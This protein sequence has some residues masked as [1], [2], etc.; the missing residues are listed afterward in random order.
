MKK[1]IVFALPTLQGGGAEKVISII[2]SNLDIR[3]YKIHLVVFDL[4][5]Q[6]YLK[7]EKV[8]IINLNSKKVSLGFLNFISVIKNLNPDILIS[9]VSHL[10][11]FVSVIRKFLPSKLKVITRESNFLSKN[12]KFQSFNYMVKILYKYF[13]NNVDQVIV[14]SK[15]HKLDMIS[16][17]NINSKKIKIIPNPI[18]FENIIKLSKIKIKKKFKK[19]FI[20]HSLKYVFVGSLSFQK[21]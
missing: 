21:G 15:K 17:T 1:K 12:I 11:L 13:Y 4:K 5:N 18:D 6:K 3:K 8:N 10:N 14:F 20:N 2:A 9:S 7:K 19:S 16:N